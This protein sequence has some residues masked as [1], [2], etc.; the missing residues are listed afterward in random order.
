MSDTHA[1]ARTYEHGPREGETILFLHGG[2]VAGWMWEPQ[3]ELLPDRHLLTPDLPGYGERWATPWPGLA[4]AADD[5]AALIRASA[6]G[7]RAHVVGLS[8]GGH[9]ALHL[10]HRHPDIVRSCTITGVAAT[11]LGPLERTL[12][13]ATVPLWHRRW[14]WAAQSF[15][16]GIPSDAR[17]Q[18]TTDGARVLPESN[19]RMFNDIKAGTLPQGDFRYQGPLLAVSGQRE[20]ASVRRA[21]PALIAAL[22]QTRTW[23][24]PKMHHAWNV[25]DAALFTRMVITHIDTGHWPPTTTV[26]EPG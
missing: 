5:T 9:V 7:G 19:R 15:A 3:V 8:L 22:P 11:A 24:A 1:G 14:F 12:V 6:S 13:A 20:A 10:M 21:F 23:I 18:F 4:A 16:F 2:N 25:E 17:E 26:P